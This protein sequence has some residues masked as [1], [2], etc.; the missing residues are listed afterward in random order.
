MWSPDVYLQGESTFCARVS[1]C[2]KHIS[3]EKSKPTHPIFNQHPPIFERGNSTAFQIFTAHFT[4]HQHYILLTVLPDLHHNEHY[5]KTCL[6]L[7][8]FQARSH[9][10]LPKRV[11]RRCIKPTIS[12]L[13]EHRWLLTPVVLDM[14]SGQPSSL[15]ITKTS[16]GLSTWKLCRIPGMTAPDYG[17]ED[18]SPKAEIF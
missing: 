5:Y 15:E 13:P 17:T 16:G 6:P 9:L 7:N 10:P 11:Y 3:W 4:D 1:F 14:N 12:P 18:A 2:E 8:L